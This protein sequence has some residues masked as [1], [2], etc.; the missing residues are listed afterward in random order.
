[1]SLQADDCSLSRLKT[2]SCQELESVYLDTAP[3]DLPEGL[4][5]GHFLYPGV[6][7]CRRAD[8]PDRVECDARRGG[9][10]DLGDLYPVFHAGRFL[11]GSLQPAMDLD[12]T[13]PALC[14][15]GGGNQ[16]V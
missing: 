9:R 8:G 16:P 7:G 11:Q 14:G 3:A 13:D 2:S 15:G 10:D 6:G 1:M 12:G 4:F 5:R